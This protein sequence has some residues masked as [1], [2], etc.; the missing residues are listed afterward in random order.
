MN[1]YP[2]ILITAFVFAFVGGLTFA[3]PQ[4]PIA[5]P[6]GKS[7]AVSLT[8][9]DGRFS[10]VDAGTPLLDKYGV[11]ATFFLVPSAAQQLLAGWK[12]ATASG[13][14]RARSPGR[15]RRRPRRAG[16]RAARPGC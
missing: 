12:K 3:Q 4:K 9:D 15:S 13:H 1:N 2:K 5:W 10:Q 16:A 11:K 14:S 6:A 7:V 8:F